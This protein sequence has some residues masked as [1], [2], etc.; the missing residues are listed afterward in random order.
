MGGRLRGNGNIGLSWGE[1]EL[2]TVSGMS[3][4][5]KSSRFLRWRLFIFSGNSLHARFVKSTA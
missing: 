3:D 4:H 5:E 2:P 1:Q